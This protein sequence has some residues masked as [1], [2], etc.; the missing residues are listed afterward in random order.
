MREPG[1]R[2]AYLSARR[3]A[4]EAAIGA[5]QQACGAAV[6]TL[7]SVMS[8]EASGASVRVSAAKAILDQAFKGAELLDMEA[9]I[10]EIE[11][12]IEWQ[13]TRKD[14]GRA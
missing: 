1:F 13:E 4:V 14:L 11:E 10:T 12:S 5:L 8:D 3:Q 7:V 2:D 9:R 6:A